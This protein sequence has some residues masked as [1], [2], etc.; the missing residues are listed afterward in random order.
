MLG[1]NSLL[2]QVAQRG[3]GCPLPGSIQD[4]AVWGFEQLR[5]G[6]GVP[7]YSRGVGTRWSWR[8]LPTQTILWLYDSMSGGMA[9]SL[10]QLEAAA[11][12]Y[13]L[14]ASFLPPA[15]LLEVGTMSKMRKPWHRQ[16][17]SAMAEYFAL[18]SQISHKTQHNCYKESTS[19]QYSY[20]V[21]YQVIL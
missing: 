6:G 14:P 21:N 12:L 4:Q 10:V 5:L 2:E 18:C 16:H 7:A 9:K 15:Y 3:C 13:Q 1:R 20:I 19:S 11:Q 17:C 8:S